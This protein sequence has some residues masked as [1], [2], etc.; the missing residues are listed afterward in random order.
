MVRVNQFCLS[1]AKAVGE[2]R[3]GGEASGSDAHR[4]TK[5]AQEWSLPIEY[6]GDDAN[7][8]P[9]PEPL[10]P[11]NG[12]FGLAG[13]FMLMRMC[14]GCVCDAHCIH[15]VTHLNPLRGSG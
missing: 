13:G 11:C 5:E 2:G 12:S 7:T 10:A 14:L 9:S 4:I 1:V 3:Q 15:I 8:L 6:E